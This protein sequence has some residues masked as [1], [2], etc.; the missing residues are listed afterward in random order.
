MIYTLSLEQKSRTENFNADLIFQ[1]HK[2]GLMARFMDIKSCNPKLRPD[3]VAKK[4]GY[5]SSTFQRYRYVMKV[6][7]AFKS[8]SP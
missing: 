8:K 7:S 5:S 4:L 6:Q 2:L 1:Q 3:Q